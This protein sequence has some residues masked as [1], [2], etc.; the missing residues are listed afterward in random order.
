MARREKRKERRARK[1]IE[2]GT[3]MFIELKKMACVC[4]EH[5]FIYMF[6]NGKKRV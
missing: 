4:V 3:I 6:Y 2:E 1:E 5:V